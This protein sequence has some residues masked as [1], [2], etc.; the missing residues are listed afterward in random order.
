[1]YGSNV[2]YDKKKLDWHLVYHEAKFISTVT[3][4]VSLY[5][6]SIVIVVLITKNRQCHIF[7]VG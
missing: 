1:M 7:V 4:H 3:E 6:T 5:Y 2:Y